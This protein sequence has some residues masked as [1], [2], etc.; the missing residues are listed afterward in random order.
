MG[1]KLHLIGYRKLNGDNIPNDCNIT[2]PQ[3]PYPVK[4]FGE[5]KTIADNKIGKYINNEFNYYLNIYE[6]NKIF[7]VPFKDWTLIP[8]WLIDMTKMFNQIENEYQNY[9][10]GK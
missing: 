7:G 2:T 5:E 8:K 10:V 4:I 3:D 6:N 1:Y 9:V